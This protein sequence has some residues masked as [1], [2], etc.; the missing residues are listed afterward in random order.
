MTLMLL[1]ALAD[2]FLM[3]P[4]QAQT[5]GGYAGIGVMSV[6]TE[7]ARD[8]AATYA[9]SGDGSSTGFKAY[10]GYLWPSRLG[11]EI[12]YYDLGSYDV[13]TGTAKSDEFAVNAFAI[14]G[15]FAWPIANKFDFNAKLGLAFT[16][17]DYTC[18]TSC[19]GI[20][21]NTNKSGIAGVLGAGMGWRVAPNFSLRAD[22]VF[23]GDVTHSVGGLEA[24]Y[25]Y[26]ALSFSGQVK[27]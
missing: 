24:D 8:F 7:N 5:P 14:S 4:A 26:D 19:G 18:V 11:I 6:S 20:F 1:A 15:V 13:R 17:V 2:A 16:N 23:I 3:T 27:F 22:L 12:G 10:G 21:V 9:T 25:A